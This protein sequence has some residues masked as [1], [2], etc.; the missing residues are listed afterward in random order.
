M[1]SEELMNLTGLVLE[2]GS[3]LV[4]REHLLKCTKLEFVNTLDVPRWEKYV[5]RSEVPLN[6][7]DTFNLKGPYTY[8]VVCRRSAKRFLL[9]SNNRSIVEAMA[10]DLS[11]LVLPSGLNQTSISVD[12][13]VRDLTEKPTTYVLSSVHAR[14]P[15]FGVSLRAVSFYGDDVG[16]ASLFRNNM[17]HTTFFACGLRLAAGGNELARLGSDGQISFLLTDPRRLMEVERIL[18]FLRSNDYLG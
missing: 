5:Y 12:K 16:E 9:A 17:L 11:N 1:N 8:P 3:H 18:V 6:R 2:N 10:Q 7:E 13:L 4:Q 14:V 15:G